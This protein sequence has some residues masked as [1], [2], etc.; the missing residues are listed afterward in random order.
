MRKDAQWITVAVLV[1]VAAVVLV[2]QSGWSPSGSRKGRTPQDAI[3]AMLDAAREGGV[4]AYLDSYS[5]PLR[6]ELDQA[7][8]EQGQRRFGEYLRTS[9][10]PIKGIAITE[11]VPLPEGQVKARVEYVYQDRNEVQW[12]YLQQV[13]GR[14]RIARVDAAQRIPTLVP[15]GTPVE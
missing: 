2:R 5:G 12:M 15:Y 14:W 6:A 4:G 11:P 13:D 3:Y 7:V 9:N 10:A 1:A 8:R